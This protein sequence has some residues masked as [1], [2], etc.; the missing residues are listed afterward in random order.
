M[1]STMKDLISPKTISVVTATLTAAMLMLSVAL[2]TPAAAQDRLAENPDIHKPADWLKFHAGKLG[3]PSS[4]L[5]K[6]NMRLESVRIKLCKE[7][8]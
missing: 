8:P 5:S 7:W 4:S 1:E 6:N 3:K 2:I